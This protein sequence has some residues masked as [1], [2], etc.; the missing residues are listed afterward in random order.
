MRAVFLEID[1]DE[2][3]TGISGPCST[4]EAFIADRSWM[5]ND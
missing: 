1:T 2:G 5:G 4:Q 3:V